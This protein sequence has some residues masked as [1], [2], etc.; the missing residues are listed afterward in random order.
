MDDNSP[1]QRFLGGV[2]KWFHNLFHGRKATA[3]AGPE[4]EL[5]GEN[6]RNENEALFDNLEERLAALHP[7]ERF[8]WAG[9]VKLILKHVASHL[10]SRELA[11]EGDD[12]HQTN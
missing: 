11:E 4:R 12:A 10:K 5:D 1:D 9:F 6:A 3:G 8:D 2:G 7:D